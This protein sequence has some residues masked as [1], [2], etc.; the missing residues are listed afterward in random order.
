MPELWRNK[1]FFGDNLHIMRKHIPD[2]SVDLINLDPLFNCEDD[3]NIHNE[4]KYSRLQI[5]TIEEILSGKEIQYPRIGADQMY[6]KA[7]RK[8]EDTQLG[9][10]PSKSK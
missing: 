2:E 9:I 1:L 10:F 6:K 8:H 5:L 3:C 7:K 4:E